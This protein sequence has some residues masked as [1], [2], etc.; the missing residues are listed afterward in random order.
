MHRRPPGRALN[1]SGH[2]IRRPCCRDRLSE[3]SGIKAGLV[4]LRDGQVLSCGAPAGRAQCGPSCQ[5][6]RLHLAAFRVKEG[7]QG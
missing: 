2:R 1:V 6:H 4:I 5:L 3:G 7:R